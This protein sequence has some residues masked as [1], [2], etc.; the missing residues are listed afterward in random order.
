VNF[1]DDIKLPKSGEI[2][3]TLYDKNGVLIEKIISSGKQSG[4]LY[5]QNYDEWVM[6][7]E[8]EAVLEIK[9]EKRTLKRGDFLLIA[10]DTPHRVLE[11]KDGTLWLC[12]HIKT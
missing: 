3:E 11:T 5:N 2:F 7:V 1:F 10:K 4:K 12:V 9:G 6:V 8:G